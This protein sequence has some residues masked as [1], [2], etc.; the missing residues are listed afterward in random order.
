MFYVTW[1][2]DSASD[3]NQTTSL[4]KR[5]IP[6]IPTYTEKDIKDQEINGIELTNPRF[7]RVASP[8][9]YSLGYRET[10]TDGGGVRSYFCKV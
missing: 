4:C 2:A 9:P 5:N 10:C 1:S 6:P 3:T 8:S 7:T